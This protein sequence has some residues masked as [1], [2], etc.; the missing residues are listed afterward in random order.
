[1]KRLLLSL[2]IGL[3]LLA[4][5][6]GGGG[7]TTTTPPPTP[8]GFT[9]SSLNGQYAFEMSGTDLNGN[10]IARV[11]S[12]TANG[13]GTISAAIEDVNDGGSFSFVQFTGGTY[14]IGSDGR[15]TLTLTGGGSLGG[16]LGLSITLS[17]TKAGLAV[18]VDGN[19]TSSGS[20][21]LQTASAFSLPSL[22]GQ[23][24]FD[25]AGENSSFAPLSL[26]GEF[27]MNGAGG[28]TSGMVDTNN[29]S[30]PAP[31]GPDPLSPSTFQMD[32]TFGAA[33]GRGSAVINGQT[34]AFYIVDGTRF[35]MIEE[36]TLGIT[37][38]D[39]FQQSGT[40]P[41]QASGL[42]GNFAFI[43][44]DAAVTGNFGTIA[45]VGSAAFNAG[46]L[47][48]VSL[49]DNNSGKYSK[50][51]GDS[52]TYTVDSAGFGRGTFTFT[53]TSLGTFSY[54]FYLSSPTQAVVLETTN[55]I[56]GAGSMSAQ[57]SSVSTASLAGNYAFNWSG[58]TI[59][60]SGNIGFEE[61][62]VGEYALSSSGA[63][64]GT[65]DFT[66]LGSTSTPLFTGVALTGTFNA[67]GTG[68]NTYQ[69]MVSPG[70]GAPS[71]TIN[72]AAYVV[73]GNTVYLVTTDSTRV[74]AG[75]ATAQ[76]TP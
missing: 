16:G 10:F 67:G 62:F 12:F 45:R 44:S 30:A 64:S 8:V 1:V 33:S 42:T 56:V 17:S 47:A 6:C 5:A 31:T 66:E 48:S 11:G 3:G 53:D 24:A 61:D 69:A 70:N 38:G 39:A 36:D 23:Y 74:T 57:P 72:F 15:G 22:T 37:V 43:L 54:V 40:I 71:V 63:I 7:G 76:T 34:V 25:L 55:G 75:T 21:D 20:F 14:T 29:G 2:T 28:L 49:D 26:V 9:T 19:A 46:A 4:A 27:A 13:S 59:P 65:V 35:R 32:P 50:A 51:T 41:T 68:R 60:S 73:N 18:Q 58:V 52:G